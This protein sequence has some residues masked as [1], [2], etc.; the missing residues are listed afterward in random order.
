VR[1]SHPREQHLCH[2]NRGRLIS[3]NSKI[4][5]NFPREALFSAGLFEWQESD[6]LR[7]IEVGPPVPWAGFC[8]S[9]WPGEARVEFGCDEGDGVGVDR[10]VDVGVVG[11]SSKNRSSAASAAA[12]AA[13]VTVRPA[14]TGI[15][16]GPILVAKPANGPH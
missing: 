12:P 10:C 11:K 2:T 6:R 16:N 7:A 1:N 15:R 4:K 13:T 5:Q 8:Q 3:T 14:V 9:F